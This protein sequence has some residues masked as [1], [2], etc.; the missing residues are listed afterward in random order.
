MDYI[1]SFLCHFVLGCIDFEDL[2]EMVHSV[3]NIPIPRQ[4]LRQLL[5]DALP[6][7]CVLWSAAFLQYEQGIKALSIFMLMLLF[8]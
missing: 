8:L 7:E 5:L 1:A 6:R 3:P 2:S 4:R